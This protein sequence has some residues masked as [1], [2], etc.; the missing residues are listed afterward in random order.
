MVP[1]YV[2]SQSDF[3]FSQSRWTLRVSFIPAP[4]WKRVLFSVRLELKA[5]TFRC[6]STY[7]GFHWGSYQSLTIR[8]EGK[9]RAIQ[10]SC[11]VLYQLLLTKDFTE[12]PV[13]VW[14]YE[15]KVR[16][17]I[18]AVVYQLWYSLLT[19]E[20]T[21][22]LS[23][24]DNTNGRWLS[25]PASVIVTDRVEKFSATPLSLLSPI[26]RLLNCLPVTDAGTDGL[27]MGPPSPQVDLWPTRRILWMVTKAWTWRSSLSSSMRL[28]FRYISEEKKDLITFN[29]LAMCQWQTL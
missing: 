25:Y 26:P 27:E 29:C 12:A 24:F 22:L 23:E 14:Q 15:W 21:R 7:E 16:W 9:I 19:K 18:P 11:M 6:D 5:R 13:R 17:S 10:L 1:D 28:N 2:V 4:P 20:F 8:M 3:F